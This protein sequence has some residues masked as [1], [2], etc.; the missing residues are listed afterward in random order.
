[1][2]PQKIIS[3]SFSEIT[4]VEVK[5]DCGAGIVFPILKDGQPDVPLQIY[6]CPACNKPWWVGQ[7]DLKRLSVAEFIKAM[8]QWQ[9]TGESARI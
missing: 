3:I 6:N 5:C 7:H 1:M 4:A 9:A 2:T 8:G